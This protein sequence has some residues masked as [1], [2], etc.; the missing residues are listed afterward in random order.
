MSSKCW[1]KPKN[2]DKVHPI[3]KAITLQTHH[4]PQQVDRDIIV[5]IVARMAT[6]KIVALRRKFITNQMKKESLNK[7]YVSTKL[8]NEM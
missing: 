8:K 5:N 7:C 6:P 2:K 1:E 4:M 3:G